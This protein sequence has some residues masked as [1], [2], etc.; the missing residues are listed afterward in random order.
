MNNRYKIL[1]AMLINHP[2]PM[3]TDSVARITRMCPNETSKELVAMCTDEEPYGALVEP[4]RD[5]WRI[6]GRCAH[7][8][9]SGG[10][11]FLV[12]CEANPSLQ[13]SMRAY[14]DEV[15]TGLTATG[16]KST[17][18]RGVLPT[19]QAGGYRDPEAAAHRSNKLTN[20]RTK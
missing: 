6:A 5:G 17:I 1:L 9:H 12:E 18:E 16:K 19:G 11:A 14:K 7:D 3:G 15:L 10:F 4:S 13:L 2:H 8:E 20:R